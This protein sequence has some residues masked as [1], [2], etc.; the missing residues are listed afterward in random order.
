[1]AARFI[2]ECQHGLADGLP[3]SAVDCPRVA[4]RLEG[5]SPVLEQGQP[6]VGAEPC[7]IAVEC[8]RTRGIVAQPV[9]GDEV[10]PAVVA[11]IERGAAQ[12]GDGDAPA[13][14]GIGDADSGGGPQPAGAIKRDGGNVIETQT[15]VERVERDRLVVARVVWGAGRIDADDAV[16]GRQP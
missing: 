15:A 8:Q 16:A 14:P 2:Q 9:L 3:V 5:R 6:V 1:M 13:K 10:A 11:G 7:R 4:G 12:V